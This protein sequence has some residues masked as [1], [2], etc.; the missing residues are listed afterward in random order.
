M[1]RLELIIYNNIGR[2]CVHDYG[3][4]AL[5][6]WLRAARRYGDREFV[7][8]CVA[9]ANMIDWPIRLRPNGRYL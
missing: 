2:V 6:R 7:K 5:A 1:T 4:N 9:H 3:R 8:K